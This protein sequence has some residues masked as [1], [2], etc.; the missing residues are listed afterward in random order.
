MHFLLPFPS[1]NAAYRGINSRNS[2]WEQPAARDTKG[3][4]G[5]WRQL[6]TPA[7]PTRARALRYYKIIIIRS[8]DGD[9][10]S[11]SIM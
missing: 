2:I 9:G 3:A 1:D 8:T 10:G 4:V 11:I 5:G 7:Y 6:I